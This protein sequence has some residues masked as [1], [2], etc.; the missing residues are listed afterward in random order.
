M[1]HTEDLRS[2]PG[3]ALFPADVPPARSPATPEPGAVGRK[4]LTRSLYQSALDALRVGNLDGLKTLKPFCVPEVFQRG[5]WQ[6]AYLESLAGDREQAQ[7]L[8]PMQ[9][10]LSDAQNR[11]L[12]S[13]CTE[14]QHHLYTEAERAIMPYD[15]SSPINHSGCRVF[16]DTLTLTETGTQLGWEQAPEFLARSE[17]LEREAPAPALND[18]PVS[19]PSHTRRWTTAS[20]P[21]ATPYGCPEASCTPARTKTFWWR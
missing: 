11:L 21:R 9:A 19:S 10:I 3:S 2:P 13:L 6:R 5:S 18:W 17:A 14:Y 7:V 16:Q 1:K 8:D 20:L 12:G 4:K 15:E